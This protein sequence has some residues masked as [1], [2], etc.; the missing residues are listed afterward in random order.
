MTKSTTTRNTHNRSN[1]PEDL[2]YI[3][4]IQDHGEK[5]SLLFI[6]GDMKSSSVIELNLSKQLNLI[7]RILSI[8]N[9]KKREFLTL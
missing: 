7:M 8:C 9:S 5:V 3:L 2:Q 4:D 6:V 1:I